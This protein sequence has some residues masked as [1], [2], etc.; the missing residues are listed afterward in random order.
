MTILA[1]AHCQTWVQQPW[2]WPGLALCIAN[3][4]SGAAAAQFNRLAAAHISLQVEVRFWDKL[5]GL[6]F[7][8]AWRVRKAVAVSPG[9]IKHMSKAALYAPAFYDRA[10]HA[11][12]VHPGAANVVHGISTTVFQNITA[13]F[14]ASKLLRMGGAVQTA[15]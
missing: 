12:R 13:V 11:V 9:T 2:W 7:Q 5:T 10:P 15:C 14:Q 3:S 6:D 1:V 4:G 8:A